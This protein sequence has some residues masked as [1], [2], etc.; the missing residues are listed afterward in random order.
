MRRSPHL[1]AL[2]LV[3]VAWS[4]GARPA[5][6]ATTATLSPIV[7]PL[8]VPA[9]DGVPTALTTADLDADGVP[10]LIVAYVSGG[11]TTLVVYPG[12]VDAVYPSPGRAAG[13]SPF[14][15]PRPLATVDGRA[16]ALSA[17]DVDGDGR[18]DIVVDG[19]DLAEA[20]VLAGRAD[21]SLASPRDLD[22]ATATAARARA[23][24]SLPAYLVAPALTPP[25]AVPSAFI[26]V[27]PD[28][29]SGARRVSDEL[30]AVLLHPAAPVALAPPADAV[31]VLP[32][33]LNRDAIPDLVVLRPDAAAPEV[34]LS[35]AA[36]TFVVTTTKDE[37]DTCDASCSIRE[38]ITAAN[39][40]P[41]ADTIE[42]AIPQSDPGF[43]PTT[44]T[45]RIQPQGSEL[46]TITQPVTIDG[47]T[48]PGFAGRP[49]IELDG[50][51]LGGEHVGLDV[52]APNTVIRALAI[53][54]FAGGESNGQNFCGCGIALEGAS[55]VVVEG[56]YI[57]TDVTGLQA[58]PNGQ[59]GVAIVSGQNN[60]I[61][62][63]TPLARNV[64]SG[65]REEFVF[66]FGVN[67]FIT[68]TPGHNVIAGNYIGV[69]RT[70][71]T[72]LP[73]LGG[74]LLNSPD[75]TV[76]GTD[77]GAGNVIA[78]NA[79]DNLDVFEAPGS[80][81][82]GNQIL[83]NFIG[84]D[85]GGASSFNEGFGYGINVTDA[86]DTVIGMPGAGNLV[87]GN[88][89][90]IFINF[91]NHNS[92]SGQTIQANG[93]GVDA[94]GRPLGNSGPGIRFDNVSDSL[95]GGT[96]NG[97]A[98][99]I[100]D[101][102]GDGVEIGF[103]G[104]C[105]GCS[106]TA[107]GDHDRV[108]SNRIFDNQFGLGIN[109]TTQAFGD[110]VTP[111]DPT[112]AD[113]G[114]NDF[115]NWP[116]LTSASSNA[117]TS[118]VNAQALT[119]GP[120][121]GQPYT[122]QFFANPACDT[123]GNGQARIF[124]GQASRSADGNAVSVN[125]SVPI[126]SGYVVTATATDS[127]GNTSEL[128]N[129][130][131]ANGGPAPVATATPTPIPTLTPSKT[132]LPGQT[133]TVAP[134]NIR[135]V[136]ICD[137]CQDDDGDGLVDRDDPDCGRPY[138]DGGGAGVAVGSRA[139]AAVKCQLALAKA[140]QGYVGKQQKLL[141]GCLQFTLVCVEQKANDPQCLVK[142]AAVCKKAVATIDALET[143]LTASVK[144]S[145]N[146]P[147]LDTSDLANAAGLGF[148]AELTSCE[149][150]PI[151]VLG[152]DDPDSV[153][154]CLAGR[155]KC[156]VGELVSEEYPRA[157]ELLQLAAVET[158]QVPCLAAGADGGGQGVG[159]AARAKALVKCAA[160]IEKATAKFGKTRLAGLQ[161]C[162]AVVD[163][164]VQQKP[165]DAA[166]LAKAQGKCAKLA[167]KIGDAPK[168]AGDKV[169]QAIA[170]ACGS[171]ATDLLAPTG[172]GQSSTA[173]YC[174]AIGVSSLATVADVADCVV[175]NQTCRIGQLLDAETPRGRELLGLAGIVP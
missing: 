15:A 76:G 87:S 129:C 108:L 17:V 59:D 21:G 31:A 57:G 51:L 152:V 32:M 111:N 155:H 38:A 49:L 107:A 141:Q 135:G 113:T 41:D 125:L 109:L 11:V 100:A 136:E 47:R 2:V 96:G 27:A 89:Y 118:T 66:H 144:K 98:N 7:V 56:N 169:R 103:Y 86:D 30:R 132:A 29:T 167:A 40:T 94:L 13:V 33:R 110:G 142:A 61:G 120:A 163:K 114:P 75:N 91:Q 151:F 147:P 60:L 127:L 101:N 173:S 65:N 106:G 122:L 14:G 126:P 77:P 4:L 104:A 92:S 1:V 54:S 53:N 130:V 116:V 48:Q 121:S 63:T 95:I 50:S 34:L 73:N 24:A 143:K 123:S 83:R 78:G 162:V 39:A 58:K 170:K 140:G 174:Q 19:D 158:F 18:K 102:S 131:P 171:D 25:A 69:D 43:Q 161:K 85:A 81:A 166:C 172:L 23:A 20:R 154:R 26:T 67:S 8:A 133:P 42:F 88:G 160:G 55:N 159:D 134:T 90:G 79:A 36:A 115:L 149:Q 80:V 37:N 28:G 3:L 12:E 45:W 146:A 64:L 82:D 6:A 119:M 97:E 145:C 71:F 46:P 148:V 150:A 99:T 156:Q 5:R 175:R 153:A 35:R 128:S 9:V 124:L 105:S 168:A 165:G 117:S 74:V 70:G 138:A 157:Q 72:A 164:C 137:N 22:G 93:V 52:G 84:V 139:K 62:G 44:G 112:D 10:D 68:T 16:T